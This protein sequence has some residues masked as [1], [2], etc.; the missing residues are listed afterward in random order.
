MLKVTY[1]TKTGNI[2]SKKY[3]VRVASSHINAIV[4]SGAAIL[5]TQL[6]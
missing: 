5:D 3:P 4:R 6:L 2:V 1:Q